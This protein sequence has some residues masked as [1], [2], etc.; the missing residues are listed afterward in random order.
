VVGVAATP[1]STLTKGIAKAEVR[2]ALLRH[3]RIPEWI[4]PTYKNKPRKKSSVQ[5]SSTH[6]S[7]VSDE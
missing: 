3:E 6:M 7:T 1:C 4:V 5:K 2:A